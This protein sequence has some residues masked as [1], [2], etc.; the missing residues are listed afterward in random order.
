MGLFGKKKKEAEPVVVATVEEQKASETIMEPE[1]DETDFYRGKIEELKKRLYYDP[2]GC[3]SKAAF[4]EDIEKYLSADEVFRLITMTVNL[5]RVNRIYGRAKGDEA[6]R[7]IVYIFD[8][9]FDDFY[10]IGGEKFNILT[11]LDESFTTHIKNA[12]NHL[13]AYLLENKLNIDVYYGMADS[14]DETIKNRNTFTIIERAVKTMYEDRDKKRPNN[15]KI[16]KEEMEAKKLQKILENKENLQKEIEEKEQ[17]ENKKEAQEDLKVMTSELSSFFD[18]MKDI[19]AEMEAS[20]D[21]LRGI[22]EEE[23][24]ADSEYIPGYPF[25]HD[26]LMETVDKK[27]MKTMWYYGATMEITDNRTALHKIRIVVFPLEYQKPPLTLNTL[28]IISDEVNTHF[29]TGKNVKAGIAGTEFYINGRFVVEN[30]KGL[31]RVAITKRNDDFVIIEKSRSEKAQSGVC[32]PYHFGK[33]FFDKELFPIKKDPNTGL[34]ECIIKSEDGRFEY[35]NG[36]LKHENK[37]YQLVPSGTALNIVSV[38]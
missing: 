29:Y 14:N 36:N 13:A 30:G 21:I 34:M 11:K 27:Q 28:V 4:D 15:E 23:E 16:L 1:M 19:K 38:T 22:R 2:F 18:E 3:K 5:E 24:S 25:E 17:E 7:K 37:R 8:K 31:F 33:M 32:T 9:E 12:T 26:E 10:R 6:L 35:C 20:Q